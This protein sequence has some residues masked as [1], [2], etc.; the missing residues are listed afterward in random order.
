M[1]AGWGG[2]FGGGWDGVYMEE[3][4]GDYTC[5]GEMEAL[6]TTSAEGAPGVT[7]DGSKFGESWNK[8]PYEKNRNWKLETMKNVTEIVLYC[9]YFLIDREKKR[10]DF[11][12]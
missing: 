4:G 9:C 2:M 5:H 11:R 8:I 6:L 7:W 1:V 3:I 12:F 10:C